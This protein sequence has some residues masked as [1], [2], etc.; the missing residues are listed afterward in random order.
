MEAGFLRLDVSGRKGRDLRQAASIGVKLN[1]TFRTHEVLVAEIDIGVWRLFSNISVMDAVYKL[2]L[3][4]NHSPH[5]QPGLMR[6][7]LLVTW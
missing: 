7:C 6:L 1:T 4:G 2:V 5:L 3:S